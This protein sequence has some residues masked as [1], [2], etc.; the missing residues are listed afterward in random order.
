MGHIDT[1]SD[2]IWGG[3]F[4]RTLSANKDRIKILWQHDVTQPPIGIPLDVHEIPRTELPEK[5]LQRFPDSVG[6]L[7]GKIRYM[8]TPRG[9]EV[10]TGLKEGAITENSIGFTPVLFDFEKVEKGDQT[11]FVCNLRDVDLFD[12]S[13]VNW[14]ANEAAQVI[15]SAQIEPFEVMERLIA[16]MKVGRVFSAANYGRLQKIAEEL[17]SLLSQIESPEKEKSAA[18]YRYLVLK[19]KR[20]LRNV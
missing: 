20:G 14:G 17:A 16:E 3:A 5:V 9:N 10:L 2:R 7:Y 13:P 15:K 12:L 19:V 8:D 1:L 4:L 18:M 6:A 11:W